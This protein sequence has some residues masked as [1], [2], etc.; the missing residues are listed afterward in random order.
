[1]DDQ[2][3]GDVAGARP[4]LT[5]R[6]VIL[7]L[8]VAVIGPAGVLAG[9]IVGGHFATEAQ[10]QRL[11]ADRAA[12]ARTKRE[13]TYARFLRAGDRYAVETDAA[14]ADCSRRAEKAPPSGRFECTLD[15]LTPARLAYQGAINRLYVYGSDDAIEAEGGNLSPPAVVVEYPRERCRRLSPSAGKPSSLSHCVPALPVGHVSRA[16]SR[17]SDQLLVGFGVT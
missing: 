10:E 1:M 13:R 17:A 16:T 2:Q 11:D 4:R 14:I 12:E 8:V 3:R 6:E 5:R 7:A 9:T 15:E